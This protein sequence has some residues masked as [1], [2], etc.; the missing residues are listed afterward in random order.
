MDDEINNNNKRIRQLVDDGW[1]AKKKTTTNNE[2]AT[3]LANVLPFL[4]EQNV[5]SGKDLEALIA[6]SKE[7]WQECSTHTNVWWKILCMKHYPCTKDIP[8]ELIDRIGYRRL[9]WIWESKQIGKKVTPPNFGPAELPLPPPPSPSCSLENVML[10]GHVKYKGQILSSFTL[11]KE[12]LADFFHNRAEFSR[13]IMIDEL[14]A[15]KI[16]KKL[17][18]EI[19][20]H[21]MLKRDSFVEMACAFLG[22]NS[23]YPWDVDHIP[24]RDT[25][26]A[27]DIHSVWDGGDFENNHYK[28]AFD[29]CCEGPKADE[30]MNSFLDL[31]FNVEYHVGDNESFDDYGV[32]KPDNGITLLHFLSEMQM[33]PLV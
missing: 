33:Q 15:K 5:L 8:S 18:I 21:L 13:T 9:Y 6:T 4:V 23:K 7:I 28:L 12:E 27:R 30:E 25:Q 1:I 32:F 10:F 24:L 14:I 22:I 29:A 11:S 17:D 31:Y 2:A 26:K 20:L 16:D 3:Y 19:K